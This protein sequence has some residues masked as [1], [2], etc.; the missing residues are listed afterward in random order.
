MVLDHDLHTL[1][2]YMIEYMA[3]QDRQT[4]ESEPWVILV[5]VGRIL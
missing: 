3:V 4:D 5:A 2:L 1:L